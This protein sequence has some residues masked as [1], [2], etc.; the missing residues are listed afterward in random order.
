M[1]LL[2]IKDNIQQLSHTQY[3]C[4]VALSNANAHREPKD[5]GTERKR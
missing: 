4:D 1:S 2:N 5:L 3:L